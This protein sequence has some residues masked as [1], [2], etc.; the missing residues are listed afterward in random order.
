MVKKRIVF[1]LLLSLFLSPTQAIVIPIID[2]S[3]LQQQVLSY[4]NFI[5]QNAKTII[6]DAAKSRLKKELFKQQGK[7]SDNQSAALVKGL[8]ETKITIA[9]RLI[10]TQYTSI[11]N[12]CDIEAINQTISQVEDEASLPLKEQNRKNLRN[13][14]LAFKEQEILAN[15]YPGLLDNMPARQ[16]LQVSQSS[17]YLD[18]LSDALRAELIRS[19]GRQNKAF[20]K[21]IMQT[22]V[23]FIKNNVLLITLGNVITQ[24]RYLVI[25][26]SMH[27]LNRYY[28]YRISMNQ[29]LLT[30]LTIQF[31][32]EKSK[33]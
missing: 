23:Y 17:F 27:L 31:Q 22:F 5:E 29:S 28:A 33:T 25:Q 14:I 13:K 1:G 12:A 26:R 4:L 6:Y 24:K 18:E 30:A 21:R 19:I 15:H 11:K 3:N 2:P 20:K 10:A 8:S 32:L 9:N 16:I 7:G